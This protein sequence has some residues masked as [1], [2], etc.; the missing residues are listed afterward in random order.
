MGPNAQ[1]QDRP[2]ELVVVARNI[3]DVRSRTLPRVS[4]AM[5][6]R[7]SGVGIN[8]IMRIE[9]VGRRG[10]DPDWSPSFETIR[11]LANGLGVPMPALFR[12]PVDNAIR[13]EAL[14]GGGAG[15]PMPGQLPL[16]VLSRHDRRE[17]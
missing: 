11:R 10:T 12:W 17:S 8:T 15:G 4:Q 3:Y 9:G 5:L 2:H 16:I 1:P 7:R 14:D 13:L 6:A